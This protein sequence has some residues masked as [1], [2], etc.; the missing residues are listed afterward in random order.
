[1]NDSIWGALQI[2]THLEQWCNASLDSRSDTLYLVNEEWEERCSLPEA[3]KIISENKRSNTLHDPESFAFLCKFTTHLNE[4]I[5]PYR[6]DQTTEVIDKIEKIKMNIFYQ[7]YVELE[8]PNKSFIHQGITNQTIWFILKKADKKNN[9]P[10]LREC[11]EYLTRHPELL[12]DKSNSMICKD[13]IWIHDGKRGYFLHFKLI[14]SLSQDL[15]DYLRSTFTLHRGVMFESRGLYASCPLIDPFLALAR[16]TFTEIEDIER[17]FQLITTSRQLIEQMLLGC[18]FTGFLIDLETSLI[19]ICATKPIQDETIARL[20]EISMFLDLPQLLTI[21]ETMHHASL[22]IIY[23]GPDGEQTLRC[24]KDLLCSSS[25]YFSRLINGKCYKEDSNHSFGWNGLTS[26]VY[27]TQER[28]LFIAAAFLQGEHAFEFQYETMDEYLQI[29]ECYAVNELR[30][31][32]E[33]KLIEDFT[34]QSF[35]F[36]PASTQAFLRIAREHQMQDLIGVIIPD[37]PFSMLKELE[38]FVERMNSSKLKKLWLERAEDFFYLFLTQAIQLANPQEESPSLCKKELQELTTSIQTDFKKIRKFNSTQVRVPPMQNPFEYFSNFVAPHFGQLKTLAINLLFFHSE[39]QLPIF[40]KL[41]GNN[42]LALTHLDFS[43]SSIQ[44][45]KFIT[46]VAQ[47]LIETVP[48]LPALK[49]LTLSSNLLTLPRPDNMNETPS[50]KGITTLEWSLDRQ[51]LSINFLDNYF[52]SPDVFPNLK[53]LELTV[54]NT[55][56]RIHFDLSQL[57]DF[58]KLEKLVI[59]F[60]RLDVGNVKRILSSLDWK[61]IASHAHLAKIEIILHSFQ[62]NLFSLPEPYD[63]TFD[64]IREQLKILMGCGKIVSAPLLGFE[65][66]KIKDSPQAKVKSRS[67]SL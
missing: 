22:F 67:D 66:K 23:E 19:E 57:A 34:L 60:D 12:Q 54:G 63:E 55:P 45:P 59:K 46:F 9:L 35:S 4:L 25:P 1:M 44:S 3:L 17:L 6:S 36:N 16:G 13:F 24:S 65:D 64:L 7:I 20:W 40:F 30:L 29:A 42:F 61:S 33:Q 58:K 10:L 52:F 39:N 11:S 28:G 18:D 62:S 53:I 43:I 50:M 41:L 38:T 31:V 49:K 37:L 48:A 21:L 2:Q 15:G 47:L 51:A 56:E 5:G 26:L 14:T 27:R 8:S 32:I